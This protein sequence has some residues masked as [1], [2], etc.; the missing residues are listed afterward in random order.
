MQAV[1]SSNE[2]MTSSKKHANMNVISMRGSM[3][4]LNLL[5]KLNEILNNYHDKERN[6]SIYSIIKYYYYNIRLESKEVEEQKLIEL[7]KYYCKKIYNSENCIK[8]KGD[9]YLIITLGKEIIKDIIESNVVELKSK[10]NE[11]GRL[12][13]SVLKKFETLR[14]TV[15]N[16]NILLNQEKNSPVLNESHKKIAIKKILKK[17]DEFM[18]LYPNHPILKKIKSLLESNNKID[19]KKLYNVRHILVENINNRNAEIITSILEIL[20]ASNAYEII[21][22]NEDNYNNVK[23]YDDAYEIIDSLI[24]Y[25]DN[26]MEKYIKIRINEKINLRELLK[27]HYL[28]YGDPPLEEFI[29]LIKQIF[30]KFKIKINFDINDKYENIIINTKI[31]ILK[32]IVLIMNKI[33]LFKISLNKKKSEESKESKEYDKLLDN[34]NLKIELIENSLKEYNKLIIFKN[35][36]EFDYSILYNFHTFLNKIKEQNNQNRKTSLQDLIDVYFKQLYEEHHK[37]S[38][39]ENTYKSFISRLTFLLTNTKI[40]TSLKK[41]LTI[42]EIYDI[43]KENILKIIGIILE[44]IKK[45]SENSNILDIEQKFKSLE[46]EIESKKLDSKPK[47]KISKYSKR[48]E[49]IKRIL[50]I[51]HDLRP[52]GKGKLAQIRQSLIDLLQSPNRLNNEDIL[53][54]IKELL[55]NNYQN[56]N[57]ENI[58]K[59]E[60]IISLILNIPKKSGTTL[61]RSLANEFSLSA[62]NEGSL[63]K[64]LLNRLI[65]QESAESNASLTDH[66]LIV[67]LKP[68]VSNSKGASNFRNILDIVYITEFITN[69]NKLYKQIFVDKNKLK[70]YIKESSFFISLNHENNQIFWDY[71]DRITISIRYNPKTGFYINIYNEYINNNSKPDYHISMHTTEGRDPIIH[72]KNKKDK[73]TVLLVENKGKISLKIEGGRTANQDRSY[74]INTIFLSI[75][76]LINNKD[77]TTY[78]MN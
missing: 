6:I 30:N 11:S 26:M 16:E 23:Y 1:K 33:N 73:V 3:E 62:L 21:N 31:K 68:K 78:L 45:L 59:I 15:I 60:Q 40:N 4:F 51:S 66:P 76:T 74:F 42:K 38:L 22:N 64:K 67:N 48:L 56:I 55:P 29:L 72:Y 75:L 36:M 8:D 54:T 5:I 50:E 24:T 69:E 46:I 9:Y 65:S 47:K 27:D 12:I 34:Y 32:L 63:N 2:N 53:R 41:K 61:E 17:L 19:E 70:K 77:L 57:A 10:Y 49:N 18:T 44:E 25:L 39:D 43:Q 7:L 58:T 52:F 35:E 14:E 20:D 13:G 71:F 37:L 28:I